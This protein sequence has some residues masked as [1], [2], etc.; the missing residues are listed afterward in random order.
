MYVVML[1]MPMAA[2]LTSVHV[3]R[4]IVGAQ[5]QFMHPI[6]VKKLY[7]SICLPR[8]LYGCELWYQ[9]SKTDETCYRKHTDSASNIF[10]DLNGERGQLGLLSRNPL[11]PFK[12]W[13]ASKMYPCMKYL[14]NKLVCISVCM[15]LSGDQNYFCRLQCAC[16]IRTNSVL[17]FMPR[18]CRSTPN[19]AISCLNKFN[20][21]KEKVSDS[22]C[23]PM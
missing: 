14:F 22:K 7:L 2:V 19:E 23:K 20:F 4:L 17:N 13:S 9:M 16:H 12:L 8:A 15:A 1:A 6:S 3:R 21:S 5:E 18:I 11:L 10:K